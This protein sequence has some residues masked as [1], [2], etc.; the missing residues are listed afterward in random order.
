MIYTR[1]QRLTGS[2]SSMH[3]L[4]IT[5]VRRW[6][7][8]TMMAAQ[9][10][11]AMVSWVIWT[12]IISEIVWWK[13]YEINCLHIIQR[14]LI[15]ARLHQYQTVD[16]NKHES[17]VVRISNLIYSDGIIFY[18]F[19][20][21]CL[22]YSGNTSYILTL[23]NRISGLDLNVNCNTKYL[24]IQQITESCIYYHFDCIFPFPLIH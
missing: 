13:N 5:S 19:Q 20:K 12:L 16:A 1:I 11:T 22:V 18:C 3:A 9:R 8:V 24:I 4:S 7:F 14:L 15:R 21:G 23:V 6:L 10:R 17:W 2:V